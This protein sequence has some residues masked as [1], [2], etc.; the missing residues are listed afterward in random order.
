MRRSGGDGVLVLAFVSDSSYRG[1][2]Q[3]NPVLLMMPYLTFLVQVAWLYVTPC[4]YFAGQ[5]PGIHG[6]L[7]GQE[8]RVSCLPRYGRPRLEDVSQ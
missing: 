7:H 5:L 3:S 6:S 2:G 4:V 8:Y 1:K